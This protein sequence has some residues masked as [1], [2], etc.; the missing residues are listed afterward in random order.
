MESLQGTKASLE[1]TFPIDPTNN[2]LQG[3]NNL[4]YVFGLWPISR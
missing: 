4:L 3:S 1:V 2:F